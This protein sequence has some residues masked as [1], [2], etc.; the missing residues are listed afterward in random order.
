EIKL[1]NEEIKGIKRKNLAKKIAFMTQSAE[2]YF[3]YTVFETVALGRYAH[4]SGAF[5]NI[6]KEDNDIILKCIEDVGLV[7]YKDRLI[8]EL[9]G[10]QL[11]RVYLAR[12]FAQDPDIIL[13]DE[14]TNH[15]DLK[16]Q[17]EI[18]Q[19]INKWTKENNKTVIGVL[20]DLNLVQMF[21]EEVIMIKEGKIAASGISKEVLEQE[22]LKEVYGLD[23]KKFMI[24][25]LEKWI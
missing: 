19:H 2:I 5:S 11:Q 13:L 15:L 18:L 9:S 8:N 24:E 21:S 3:P 23:I 4:Q 17:I 1:D 10:G 22:K 7:E 20:H 25:A 14:P 16:C 6:S 12:V